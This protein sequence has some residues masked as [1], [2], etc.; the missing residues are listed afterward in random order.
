MQTHLIYGETNNLLKY[1]AYEEY[2]KPEVKA[3]QKTT[4]LYNSKETER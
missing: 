4:Q 3:L 2:A 1:V